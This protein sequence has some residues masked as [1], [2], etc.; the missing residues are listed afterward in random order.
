[1][2]LEVLKLHLMQSSWIGDS[3]WNRA[4]GNGPGWMLSASAS[5]Q[6]AAMSCMYGISMSESRAC[7]VVGGVGW[8]VTGA[9]GRVYLPNGVTSAGDR[10][11]ALLGE[12]LELPGLRLCSCFAVSAF[13]TL[14]TTTLRVALV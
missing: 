11:R 5:L 13:C 10:R 6:C 1:M 12:L 2:S 4:G 9:V 3:S 7:V 8:C 14:R